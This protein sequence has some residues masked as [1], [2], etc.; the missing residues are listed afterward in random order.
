M[1]EEAVRKCMVADVEV[2]SFLSGELDS[3]I[4]ASHW[5]GLVAVAE[6]QW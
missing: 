2:G 6:S 4:S 1:L 5:G 3:S